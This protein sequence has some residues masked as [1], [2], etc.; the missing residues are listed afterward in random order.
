V[1]DF[2]AKTKYKHRWS[3]S[4]R[5]VLI[6]SHSQALHIIL[7]YYLKDNFANITLDEAFDY[8]EGAKKIQEG[9]KYKLILSDW[10]D[11]FVDGY[12]L[13]VFSRQFPHL[14]DIPFVIISDKNDDKSIAKCLNSSPSASQYV[15]KPI[16]DEIIRQK[17]KP[18][19]DKITPENQDSIKNLNIPA[20]PAII[21]QLYAELGK[22]APDL[23]NIVEHIKKDVA[24]TASLIRLSN[25][26]IY[27][28]GKVDSIERALQ[29]LGLNNFKNMVLA[30]SIQNAVKSSG[31]SNEVFQKHCVAAAMVCSYLAEKKNPELVDAAYLTGL[32]H[33]C[34]IPLFMKR[35]PDYAEI[36]DLALSGSSEIIKMEESIIDTNH[37]DISA[38]IVNTWKVEEK[39]ITAMRSHHSN[40]VR[41]PLSVSYYHDAR[42]LWAMLVL[43]E[44]ICHHYGYAGALP[45]K[46]DE[47]FIGIYDNVP[48]ALNVSVEEVK[49]LREGAASVMEKVTG[50]S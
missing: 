47:E 19:F 1:Q 33:D 14:T 30:S 48:M 8:D 5:M 46:S 18:F 6:V 36:F 35:S 24:I 32:F 9:N 31:A 7:K 23:H 38:L 12:K 28:A 25:A 27:G 21:A 17:L 13:L 42:Q 39:I 49:D 3:A 50:G 34:A 20:C 41:I 4:K 11:Q 40:D 22:L 15:T 43:S 16:N 2:Y 26:P 45:T 10:D 44:H 37:A 29:V